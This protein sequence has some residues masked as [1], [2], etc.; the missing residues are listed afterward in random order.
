MCMV[1]AGTLY[2]HFDKKF[3]PGDCGPLHKQ[4]FLNLCS[5]SQESGREFVAQGRV[6][7]SSEPTSSELQPTRE[8]HPDEQ[9]HLLIYSYTRQQAASALSTSGR[10][11]SKSEFRGKCKWSFKTS[12]KFESKQVLK[13]EFYQSCKCKSMVRVI[14]KTY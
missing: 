10:H 2:R 4:L 1:L 9:V 13:D 3:Q 7:T 5:Q 8:V 14:N 11:I 12:L 6:P